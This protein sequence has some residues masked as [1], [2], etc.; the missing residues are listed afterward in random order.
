ML[1]KYC[2]LLAF[3]L[4][5]MGSVAIAPSAQAQLP[6]IQDLINYSRYSQ[7]ID[8]IQENPFEY[9]CIHLDGRCLFKIASTASD[10]LSDRIEKIQQPLNELKQTYLTNPNSQIIVTPQ[11]NSNLW[12]VHI[13]IASKRGNQVYA[14]ERL[15]TVTKPDAEYYQVPIKTRAEQIAQELQQSMKIARQEREAEF[16]M[17]QGILA[18][19]IL[20]AMMLGTVFIVRGIRNL[21][22]NKQQ[23]APADVFL[24]PIPLETQLERRRK[25]NLK[26]VQ[27]RL[28]ELALLGVW[29]GG[30]LLIFN[31]FPQTRILPFLIVAALRIPARICLVILITYLLIRLT[32]ALIAKLSTAFLNNYDSN[33]RVNQRPQLRISTISRILRGVTTV[34]WIGTGILVALGISGVNITPI[35]AGAG[36]LGLAISLASQNLIKDTINGFLIIL[37]DQ[38]AVGDVINVGGFGGLV[39][40]INLRITQLRDAEGRLITIPNSE[41]KIVANHSNQWSRADVSIPISYHT[42]V[43]KA[44]AIIDCLGAELIADS[45]WHNVIWESP[46]ILGVESFSDRGIIIRVWIKTEPLKQWEVAREFRRRAIIAFDRAGMP[47]PLPQQQIWLE[48]QRS[49]DLGVGDVPNP[50]SLKP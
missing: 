18:G 9:A 8:Q 46:Q 34:V 19:V 4:S 14:E 36:I 31:L 44:I 30:I 2:C 10:P 41:I 33:L 48:E 25:R 20:A 37:E 27:Y 29:L 42:D 50:Q 49:K 17:R 7:V 28:L 6:F 12:D 47:I 45:K 23:L 40:N 5:F 16:L 38:Y 11:I 15:L 43:E 26:E 1:K 22:Q 13:K 35:L 24:P 32:Y 21:Q 3:I 39:E